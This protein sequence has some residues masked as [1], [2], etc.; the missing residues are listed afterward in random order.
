M[1]AVAEFGKVRIRLMG[2]ATLA[3]DRASYNRDARVYAV[4]ADCQQDSASASK[5]PFVALNAGYQISSRAVIVREE[6][7]QIQ[8]VAGTVTGE[9]Y[10]GPRGRLLTFKQMR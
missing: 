2:G 5:D 9:R 8:S 10:H 6:D 3:Y 7:T 1:T 4:P